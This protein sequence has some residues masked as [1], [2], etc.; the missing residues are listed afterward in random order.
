LRAI[1]AATF[2]DR[3]VGL[4]RRHVRRRLGQYLRK[5]TFRPACRRSGRPSTRS[6]PPAQR[7]ILP[8][9]YGH[10]QPDD[11]RR[12]AISS[13]EY[14]RSPSRPARAAVGLASNRTASSASESRLTTGNSSADLFRP[15][16]PQRYV[17]RHGRP[18]KSIRYLGAKPIPPECP[19]HRHL[20]NS[21]VRRPESAPAVRLPTRLPG[22]PTV[23]MP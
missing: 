7:R 9:V 10:Q 19:L 18:G 13:P 4:H 21:H 23:K 5:P 14:R 1:M 22:A 12:P 17:R 15:A 8:Y 6:A 20:R 11:L 16:H 3:V 2:D